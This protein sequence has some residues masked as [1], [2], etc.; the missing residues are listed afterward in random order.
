MLGQK[1]K[2]TQTIAW[3]EGLT[4]LSCTCSNKNFS[5]TENLKLDFLDKE[6]K[7]NFFKNVNL[8]KIDTCI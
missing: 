6:I 1:T 4:E 8:S 5:A 7:F 2:I 3:A